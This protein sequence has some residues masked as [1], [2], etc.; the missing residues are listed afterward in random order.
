MTTVLFVSILEKDMVGVHRKINSLITELKSFDNIIVDCLLISSNRTSAF[1]YSYG[2]V[3]YVPQVR[4]SW[5]NEVYK[6]LDNFIETNY[7]KALPLIYFRYPF[8]DKH[9]YTFVKKYGHRI[10]FEHNTIEEEELKVYFKYYRLRD[11]LYNLKKLD[12]SDLMGKLKLL[13]DENGYGTKVLN[14]VIGGICVTTEIGEYENK[15]SSNRY[16]I[17]IIGN[18]LNETVVPDINEK[19][20]PILGVFRCAFVAGHANNWHGVD[21]ILK[22]I[23]GYNGNIKIEI[24]YVG[25]ILHS[26]KNIIK[27]LGLEDNIIFIETCDTEKL[28]LILSSCHIGISSLGLHRI[29]LKQGSV[30][31]TREY[32]LNGLPTV[33]SYED[34]DLESDKL[35]SEFIIKAPQDDSPINFNFI[36]E[37]YKQILRIGT[38]KKKI[39]EQSIYRFGVKT[40]AYQLFKSLKPFFN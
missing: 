1:E 16:T 30:L 7:K 32:L 17:N 27:N 5:Y 21:R 33:F 38:S 3:L 39:S 29:P 12:F 37:R 18:A 24:I 6:S 10:I 13:R 19:L 36:L 11:F 2:R 8:A 28:K 15:R 34:E 20:E 23:S 14:R 4:A 35:L 26:V 9:L 40:K 22:G 31:K 25:K